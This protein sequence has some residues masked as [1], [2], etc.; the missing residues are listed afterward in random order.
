MALRLSLRVLQSFLIL[1]CGLRHDFFFSHLYNR[2]KIET[3]LEKKEVAAS[4]ME[5]F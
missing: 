3:I 4:R 2:R 5:G 1:L